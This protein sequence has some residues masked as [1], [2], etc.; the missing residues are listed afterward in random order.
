MT[1]AKPPSQAGC[2]WVEECIEVCDGLTVYVEDQ[3]VRA[4]FRNPKRVQVRKV[5]Y[6]NC[7]SQTHGAYHADFILCLPGVVDVV[8]ELKGSHTN[9]KHAAAQVRSTLDAWALDS[10]RGPRRAALIIYG[11]IYKSDSLPRRQPKARSSVQTV[12][13][14]FK[15]EVHGKTLLLIHEHGERQF[16][17]ND[18]LRKNDAR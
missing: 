5:H 4:T 2:V 14:D 7:Y 6:D 8:I 13:G 15:A 16:N 12:I 11:M 18:F 3:G 9:L 1:I 17:F 10:N